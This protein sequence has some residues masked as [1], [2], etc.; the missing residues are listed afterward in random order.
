MFDL[1]VNKYVARN[2][3]FYNFFPHFKLP[4]LPTFKEKS[5]YLAVLHIRMVRHPN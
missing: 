2:S 3:R 1:Y 5:N 4:M